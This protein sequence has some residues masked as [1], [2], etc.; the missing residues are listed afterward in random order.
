[1]EVDGGKGAAPEKKR[2][3]LLDWAEETGRG[4]F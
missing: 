1:M 4:E 3:P 2:A